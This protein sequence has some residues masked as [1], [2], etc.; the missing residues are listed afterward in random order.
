MRIQSLL[1]WRKIIVNSKSNTVLCHSNN[2]IYLRYCGLLRPS[3]NRC[4]ASGFSL[5][6]CL[7]VKNFC[8]G[9]WMSD[10]VF[11]C[12]SWRHP[13]FCDR[14]LLIAAEKR[15][16]WMKCVLSFAIKRSSRCA[17]A[18]TIHLCRLFFHRQT[19]IWESI[20]C[21]CLQSMTFLFASF[22]ATSLVD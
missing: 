5:L 12:I 17:F 2:R 3:S 7:L 16:V 4:S 10:D 13:D 21:N 1:F 11:W 6:S 14:V 20:N 19:S 15:G 9:S 22:A 8:V 18:V